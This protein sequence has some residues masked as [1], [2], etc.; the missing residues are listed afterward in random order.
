[1]Y[2]AGG[3]GKQTGLISGFREL[4]ACHA[5]DVYRLKKEIAMLDINHII[6][7][8]A[9]QHLD[10]EGNMYDLEH[11]SPLM[12]Q[13]LA[14]EEGIAE[15]TEAHW[16]VIYTLRN[17]YREH[18]RP[19]NVREVMRILEQDFSEEGGR[20]FLYELFPKGP[21]SQGS[22]LAGVLPP[23]NSRDPSFGWAG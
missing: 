14:E 6:N 19:E 23:P 9:L 12:V 21:V 4:Q 20:R 13:K 16:H 11:W 10:P 22:R 18:G 17:L 15:L 8:E 5:S 2:A 7:E 1:M 3:L